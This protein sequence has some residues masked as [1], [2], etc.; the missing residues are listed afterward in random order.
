MEAE[1]WFKPVTAIYIDTVVVAV[2]A[3]V[4]TTVT[5]NDDGNESADDEQSVMIK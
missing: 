3:T 2:V 5:L 4:D 1:E